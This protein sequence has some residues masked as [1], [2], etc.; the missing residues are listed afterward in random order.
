MNC[1]ICNN[2]LIKSELE[3]FYY[4]PHCNKKFKIYSVRECKNCSSALK[5][6]DDGTWFCPSCGK[7]YRFSSKKEGKVEKEKDLTSSETPP[8]SIE[9]SIKAEKE[10]LSADDKVQKNSCEKEA[11]SLNTLS[12]IDNEINDKPLS[13]TER[14]DKPISEKEEQKVDT[15]FEESIDYIPL[16]DDISEKDAEQVTEDNLNSDISIDD[17]TEE[18]EDSSFSIN[19]LIDEARKDDT[20]ASKKDEGFSVGDVIIEADNKNVEES[21]SED[22]ILAE[23][24][25]KPIKDDKKTTKKKGSPIPEPIITLSPVDDEK[26]CNEEIKPTEYNPSKNTVLTLEEMNASQKKKGS[27]KEKQQI[28]GGVSIAGLIVG[29]IILLV[30]IAY[31]VFTTIIPNII[32]DTLTFILEYVPYAFFGLMF[33]MSII[34][35]VILSGGQKAGGVFYLL[36]SLIGIG[37]IAFFKYATSLSFY[38]KAV[39]YSELIS[40]IP[41]GLIFLGG[42]FTLILMDTSEG[43]SKKAGRGGL[44]AA[45]FTAIAVLPTFA[46]KITELLFIVPYTVNV[47]YVLLGIA[48]LLLPILTPKNK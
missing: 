7:K 33:I 44:V 16:I 3:N 32:P 48:F 31:Y 6:C 2:E 28:Q 23:A 14:K 43:N 34:L 37:S 36:A 9:L 26:P 12:I 35:L 47:E 20:L 25:P 10:T 30:G 45:I 4:C 41:K 18:E 1:K 46:N 5:P 15:P 29:I 24:P 39:E 38:D 42:A 8:A 19:D 17:L 11:D 27:K 21:F 22:D 13:H 40:Y